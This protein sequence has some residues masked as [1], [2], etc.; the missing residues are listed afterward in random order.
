MIALLFL[1]LV[2]CTEDAPPPKIKKAP[3]PT[4][5]M[6]APEKKADP[7]PVPVMEPPKPAP[8]PAATP[9]SKALLDPSLP[10]WSQTAPAEY[11][12]KFSTSKG[13]FTVLVQREWAPRGAD[14]FYNLVKNGFY[15][16][17]IFFRVISGFMAQFGVNGSPEVSA[18]W[19]NAVIQDDPV[20]QSNQRGMISFA[21]RG[22]NTRTTQ[23]FINFKDNS[24][25]DGSGFAPFAK[26]VEGMEVVD[27]LYKEYGEGAPSG[28]G[29]AQGR[30]QAEGNAYLKSEFKELDCVKTARILN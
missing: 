6:R 23:I 4:P 28:R 8:A 5:V 10:D 16:G 26:V 22:P 1:S 20:V 11:K 13:D 19:K 24:R 14:R 17:T 9:V 27:S 21:M 29:P 25:L 12:V 7:V 18:A 2:G 3:D 30:I 15:D